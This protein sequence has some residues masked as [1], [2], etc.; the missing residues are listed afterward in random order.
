MRL[1]FFPDAKRRRCAQKDGEQHSC[2]RRQVLRFSASS[3]AALCGLHPFADSVDLF[4]VRNAALL[5][6]LLFCLSR[7]LAD[8]VSEILREKCTGDFVVSHWHCARQQGGLPLCL[9]CAL[10]RSVV[11]VSTLAQN[12]RTHSAL[13]D[14]IVVSTCVCPSQNH[15]YQDLPELLESDA[16]TLGLDVVLEDEEVHAL[17]QQTDQEVVARIP[18]FRTARERTACTLQQT[19]RGCC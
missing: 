16:L 8:F 3:V 11:T 1:K 18:C 9:P 13:S 10:L 5:A 4:L 15:L 19:N 17:L 14:V 12:P 6:L 2:P 7:P